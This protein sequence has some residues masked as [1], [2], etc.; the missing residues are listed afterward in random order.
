V[1]DVVNSFEMSDELID[2][3]NA[4]KKDNECTSRTSFTRFEEKLNYLLISL[5][6]D[7]LELYHY[8]HLEFCE[9]D[10]EE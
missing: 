3:I 5:G 9:C 7:E 1:N 8:D 10:F 6:R 4:Y 2:F